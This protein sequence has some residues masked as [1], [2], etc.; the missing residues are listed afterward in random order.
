MATRSPIAPPEATREK[1]AARA[2][3]SAY[4]PEAP[5]NNLPPLEYRDIPEPLPLRKVIGPSVVLVGVGISSGEYIIWPYITSQVGLIFLWAAAFGIFMQLILN[6]EIERYT[7]AT[8]ETAVAGFARFWKP[9]GLLFIA[10]AVIPNIWPGWAASSATILTFLLGGG[11]ATTIAI[12]MLVFMGVALTASPVVYKTLERIQ[13]VKVGAVL[14]F[15]VVTLVAAISSDAYGDLP[16]V[17]TDAGWATGIEVS[18]VLGALAFAGVGGANNLCQS[19]WIRDK[20]F[21]MGAHIP[22]VVSPITGE[23]QAKPS[24]GYMVR[25]DEENLRRFWGWWHVAKKEQFYFFFV[26]G[27][28]TIFVFSLLAYSTVYGDDIGEELDFIE[29]QGEALKAIVGPWFGTLFWV[30]GAVSLFA[31]MLGVIDYVSR[32]SGDA[33]KTVYARESRRLTE[34]KLYFGFVWM[35]VACGCAVL[36]SGFDQ[37]LALLI[38]AS[39]LNGVVMAIYSLLLIQ[40]NRRALPATMRVSGVRLGLLWLIAG[41]FG[42]LSVALLLSQV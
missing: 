4:A 11:N 36:L 8:G 32:V 5:S 41:V 29:G 3:E 27:L 18:V 39:S 25:Q 22:R 23:D 13:F 12:A 30:I 26:T 1:T 2:P 38:V 16:R 20:G 21:G 7:L 19:N 28:V 9:W 37:P 33:I 17:A 34:S 15:L 40:L 10:F 31:G 42:V 35:L 24:T 14:V 6:M